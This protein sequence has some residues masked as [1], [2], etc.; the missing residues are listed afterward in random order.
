MPYHLNTKEYPCKQ[1]ST[2]FIPYQEGVSCPK[3]GTV[4]QSDGYAYDFVDQVINSMK[5]H[6]IQFGMYLPGA[7]FISNESDRLQ[8]MVFD[9]FD[10]LEHDKESTF[11]TV[12]TPIILKSMNN[13]NNFTY[14]IGILHSVNLRRGEL[15]NIKR[16]S[17]NKFVGFFKTLYVLLFKSKELR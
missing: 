13:Y 4:E 15:R 8:S 3:C 14:L 16:V 1:C 12:V 7:W 11:E 5:V 10:Q 2:L 17:K 6:K 9:I